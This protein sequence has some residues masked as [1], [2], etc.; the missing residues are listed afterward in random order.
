MSN[1]I[2]WNEAATDPDVD[3]KYI[4]DM[5][6]VACKK[7]IG[8]LPKPSLEIGCG[9]ARLMEPGDYGIDISQ[10]M[11]D[12]ARQRQ[13]KGH[14]RTTKGLIPYKDRTFMSVYSML[15]F[16]HIEPVEVATY[17][18]EAFRVLKS[19]GILRFQFVMGDYHDGID[20]NYMFEEML[21]WIEKA[22]FIFRDAE[23]AVH[24]SWAWITAVKP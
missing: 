24:P 15:T 10:K 5:P 18:S 19:K 17:I 9:V 14:Y 4:C 16:Q 3:T 1:V 6:T 8:K 22:G 20:H 13:P 2:Y 23:T 21:R 12:I 7:A 11:L